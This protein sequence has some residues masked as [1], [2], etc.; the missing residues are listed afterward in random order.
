MRHDLLPLMTA[1]KGEFR[2]T[3]DDALRNQSPLVL[4]D[5]QEEAVDA[6]LEEFG[7]GNKTLLVASTGTGKTEMILGTLQRLFDSGEAK[8]AL[9]IAHTEELV[10]QPIERIARHWRLPSPGIV[11]GTDYD[12]KSAAVMTATV[13]SLVARDMYRLH[14]IVAHGN[15]DVLVLDE[16]HHS[17]ART[18]Q[19]VVSFL[20]EHNPKMRVLGTTATPRRT[21]QDG[22]SKVFDSVAYRLSLNEAIKRGILC[23]FVGKIAEMGFTLEG[24]KETKD[25]WDEAAVGDL[26]SADNALDIVL[27]KWLEEAQGRPTVVFTASVRQARE[28]ARVFNEAGIPAAWVSGETPREERRKILSG[29]MDGSIKVVANCQVLTE[30]WDAKHTSCVVM[31]KPTKSP[32]LYAQMMGRGLRTVPG[33]TE[34]LLLQFV[35]L[36]SPPDLFMVGDLLGKPKKQK[37]K[38]QKARDKGIVLDIWGIDSSGEGFEAD[39]DE[40]TMAA[41]DFFAG[42]GK[43]KYAWVFDP[44][45][46]ISTLALDMGRV[47]GII[48]PDE[49]A[50]EFAGQ[51]RTSGQWKE[52]YDKRLRF[53]SSWHLVDMH[54]KHLIIV[55]SAETQAEI[56]AM[57]DEFVT[58]SANNGIAG[59]NQKWRQ[60]APTHKRMEFAKK[61]GCWRDGMDDGMC[62]DAISHVLFINRAKA[63]KYISPQKG[64]RLNANSHSA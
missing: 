41:L 40:V 64:S 8:R 18:Y 35:P 50:I 24:I 49:E 14:Q 23:P 3:L 38:E 33:K 10:F 12:M 13:Q 9:I 56:F 51:L 52:G 6:V 30:G 22:L 42:R 44:P 36:D 16:A 1:A 37:T 46:R 20:L 21:D 58:R 26:M 19:K 39:P 25:G 43:K 29:Y 31:A 45:T 17:S 48:P 27:T 63:H 57:V 28:T 4:R 54:D 32:T 5:Y 61:L 62:A 11:M 60:R 55:G 7:Q 59:R 15:I 47:L 34:C 2:L 53:R